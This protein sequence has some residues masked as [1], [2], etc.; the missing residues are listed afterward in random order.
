[1]TPP[2]ALPMNAS[3]ARRWLLIALG[4]LLVASLFVLNNLVTTIAAGR[5]VRWWPVAGSE[6]VYWATWL[7][8]SPLLFRI[9]DRLPIERSLLRRNLPVHLGVALVIAPLQAAFAL[10][11]ELAIAELLYPRADGSTIAVFWRQ[12]PGYSGTAFWKYWIVL[13]VH[14]LV[15]YM[16]G[17]VGLGVAYRRLRGE[18]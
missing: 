7:A 3:A 6:L 2:T 17:S 8:L 14:Q 4:W 12:L 1:M 16:S 10:A 9:A 13:C 18:R 15:R 11:S 5:E